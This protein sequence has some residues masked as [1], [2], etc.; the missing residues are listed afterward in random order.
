MRGK[1]LLFMVYLSICSQIPNK[2]TVINYKQLPN[3]KKKKINWSTT[4]K[5]EYNAINLVE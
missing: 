2:E 1:Y 4:P 3:K 5:N